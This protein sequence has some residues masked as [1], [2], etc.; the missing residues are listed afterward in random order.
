MTAAT[1]DNYTLQVGTLGKTRLDILNKIYNP[2]SQQFLI[3]S[4]LCAGMKVLEIGCGTGEITCWL[5][6]QVG[7]TGEVIAIDQSEEQL[8]ITQQNAEAAGLKNI[9]YINL[10]VMQLN[11]LNERF[12]LIYSRWLLMHL[13]KPFEALQIMYDCLQPNGIL[14][15]EDGAKEGSFCYPASPIF[16]QWLAAWE[17]RFTYYGKDYNSGLKL[18]ESFSHLNC[19]IN[20]INL[21]QPVLR[22]AL[23][24]SVIPLNAEESLQANIDSGFFNSKEKA[25]EFIENLKKF[26]NE[27]HF[28]GY[29]RNTQIAAKKQ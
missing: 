7:K 1:Q 9:R 16:N 13:Q 21:F 15:C 14:T 23:E 6:Q 27:N 5:A 17:H 2:I 20:N 19:Q 25:H 24:K 26:A 10:P 28:I 3:N 12:D 11:E 18:P 29:L 22:T 8:K 4:G